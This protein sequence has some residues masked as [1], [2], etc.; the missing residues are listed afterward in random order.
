MIDKEISQVDWT[1]VRA[2]RA[3][4]NILHLKWEEVNQILDGNLTIPIEENVRK[5]VRMILRIV[6]LQDIWWDYASYPQVRP[7]FTVWVQ[8]WFRTPQPEFDNRTPLDLMLIDNK[9]GIQKILSSLELFQRNDD[10]D[11]SGTYTSDKDWSQIEYKQL[12]N[13]KNSLE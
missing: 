2:F 1:L 9:Q 3:L 6:Y 4:E 8:T 10:M 13:S 12:D 7:S 11:L 5:K